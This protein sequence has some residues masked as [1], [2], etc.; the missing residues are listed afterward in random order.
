[1]EPS[2]QQRNPAADLNDPRFSEVGESHEQDLAFAAATKTFPFAISRI[3]KSEIW[4]S[5]ETRFRHLE[6]VGKTG[7]GKSTLLKNLIHAD[8]C[9]GKS[10]IMID[11]HGDDCR[12]I[13]D[14]IPKHRTNKVCY[15]DVA[16]LDHPIAFNPLA[17]DT[18]EFAP[19]LAATLTDGFKDIWHEAWSERMAWF[20]TMGLALVTE[21][22]G[23]LLDLRP[24]Y[25]NKA[26]RD[27]L[28]T[29]IQNPITREFWLEEFPSYPDQYRR[30]APGAIVNRIGQLVASPYASRILAHPHPTLD[31]G[32]AMDNGYIVLI[33]L[34]KGTIGNSVAGILGSLFIS[35]IRSAIMARANRS[36]D[37]RQPVAL[38]IDEFQS[39]ATLSLAQLLSEAR[40]Y[41]LQVTLA[42]QYLD[43][44]KSEV[45]SAILGNVGTLIAFRVGNSDAE[46]LAPDF[47]IHPRQL[48][49]QRPFQ[50]WMK[51]DLQAYPLATTAFDPPVRDRTDAIMRQS[52]RRFSRSVT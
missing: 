35:T 10:V 9:A 3:D 30:E 44:L 1:M 28:T 45:T 48:T 42:N 8:I 4:I 50:A 19:T 13:L 37:D 40:K 17:S 2:S 41:G 36:R 24:L 29:N 46:I 52:Q 11:P 5:E 43:Q 15:V 23:T 21:K 51:T 39:F 7:S 27:R 32:A 16:D 38:Y 33:N 6:V 25:F 18:P 12:D 34:Q 47:D 14:S 31:I 26:K 22:H 49:D 20:L